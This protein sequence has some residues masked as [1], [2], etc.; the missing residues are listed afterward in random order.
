LHRSSVGKHGKKKNSK[1][2]GL[3][4]GF[5]RQNSEPKAVQKVGRALAS[6]PTAAEREG[7]EGLSEGT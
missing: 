6:W 5:L 3:Q 1:G 4:G 7:I 2:L